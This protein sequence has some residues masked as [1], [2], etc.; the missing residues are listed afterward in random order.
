MPN[1]KSNIIIDPVLELKKA[2][3]TV[4]F[5]INNG[6]FT[7]FA[8][9]IHQEFTEEVAGEGIS[10]NKVEFPDASG[11]DIGTNQWDGLTFKYKGE[12]KT[13]TD[14]LSL[15]FK[16]NI[17]LT[18]DPIVQARSYKA[19]FIKTNG[20]HYDRNNANYTRIAEAPS[21]KIENVPRVD[22]GLAERAYNELYRFNNKWKMHTLKVE[23]GTEIAGT[24]I[25]DISSADLINHVFDKDLAFT[26]ILEKKSINAVFEQ[27]D[28][29][30]MYPSGFS[31]LQPLEVENIGDLS[32]PA[33]KIVFTYYLILKPGYKWD[34]KKFTFT[35]GDD[36]EVIGTPDELKSQIITKGPVVIKP[37]LT[38]DPGVKPAEFD[39]KVRLTENDKEYWIKSSDLSKWENGEQV[40]GWNEATKTKENIKKLG[41]EEAYTHPVVDR[42]GGHY[43]IRPID[44]PKWERGEKIKGSFRGSLMDIQWIPDA[45]YYTHE[46]I[47]W[48]GKKYKIFPGDLNT[49]NNRFEVDALNES[50]EKV[51][52]KKKTPEEDGFTYI[53]RKFMNGNRYSIK[54]EDKAKWDNFEEIDGISY[55]SQYKETQRIK[56]DRI[57]DFFNIEVWIA[58]EKFYIFSGDSAVF[59]NYS[60]AVPTWD[61]TSPQP[62][63]RND[64][65]KRKREKCSEV[66][67]KK[68]KADGKEWNINPADETKWNNRENIPVWDGTSEYCK[69]KL[70]RPNYDTIYTELVTNRDNKKYYIEPGHEDDWKKSVELDGTSEEDRNTKIKVKRIHPKEIYSSLVFD[71]EHYYKYYIKPEDVSKW[72]NFEK[73]Y[74]IREYSMN[75]NFWDDNIIQEYKKLHMNE[76]FTYEIEHEGKKYYLR[77]S[78][79]LI[80]YYDFSQVKAW[81]GE[82][83]DFLDENAYENIIRPAV[84]PPVKSDTPTTPGKAKVTFWGGPNCDLTDM[85][86][87]NTVELDEDQPDGASLANLTFP[88]IKFKSFIRNDIGY[89]LSEGNWK[90]TCLLNGKWRTLQRVTTSVKKMVV[91]GNVLI[92]PNP[93]KQ[94]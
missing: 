33:S 47:H 30:F 79:D 48:D 19:V 92:Q 53:V 22:I 74:G 6:S 40:E 43:K 41:I 55:D 76:K 25:Q 82:I 34:D 31:K 28:S 7:T 32:I 14:L 35:Q 45:Q 20:V 77:T 70:T 50:G 66:Y 46:L 65:P 27:E 24:Y 2:K 38:V 85:V 87:P 29:K 94:R 60:S 11:V 5:K 10:F 91:K 26:P 16:E 86:D 84:E 13:K 63:Y 37:I 83:D 69:T 80:T 67:T 8:P 81:K 75:T 18:I 62:E 89:G 64:L 12:N 44:I 59:Y 73:V 54:P 21:Y 9:K 57:Q 42:D 52:I 1:F 61:G 3:Y 68:V 23:S 15:V 72:D 49:Y 90:V 4:D 58:G 93:G 88:N 17:E 71:E 78:D 36:P 51:K 39:S 56:N